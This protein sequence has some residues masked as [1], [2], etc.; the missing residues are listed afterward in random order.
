MGFHKI[1]KYYYYP[2]W[3][4]PGSV[5]ELI[6]NKSAFEELPKDLQ[7]IVR[8]AAYQA[9]LWIL[10]TFETK[11]NEYLQKILDEE[12]VE[13]RKFPDIVLDV[14]RKYSQEVI[15][16]VTTNDTMSKKVYDSFNFFRKNFKKWSDISEEIYYSVINV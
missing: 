14:L 9:N 16:E 5:L 2:G 7:E 13:I 4:E 6:V 8:S 3:H 11:N 15:D 10:S 1:A 12:R